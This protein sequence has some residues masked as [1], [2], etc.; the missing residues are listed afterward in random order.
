MS[1]AAKP[2]SRNYR[3]IRLKIPFFIEQ[4][5]MPLA[6]AHRLNAC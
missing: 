6:D 3:R 5:R 4:L 2:S 1:E